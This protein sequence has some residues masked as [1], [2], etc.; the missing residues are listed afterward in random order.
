MSPSSKRSSARLSLDSTSSLDPT[1][2][3]EL[4]M[5]SER[6]SLAK[7]SGLRCPVEVGLR[8]CGT[9]STSDCS[10]KPI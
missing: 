10:L 9:R 3:E 7:S 2:S 5:S 8:S 1:D 6:N 4:R